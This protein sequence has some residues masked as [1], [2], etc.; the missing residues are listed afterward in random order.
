MSGKSKPAVK[1]VIDPIDQLQGLSNSVS[2]L[3]VAEVVGKGPHQPL[4]Y[5]WEVNKTQYVLTN[6]TLYWTNVSDIP[7]KIS[8]ATSNALEI[9]NIQLS[10]VGF[11]RVRLKS[12]TLTNTSD[13]GALQVWHHSIFTVTGTPTVASGNSGT[14]PGPYKGLLTYV[15]SGGG[16][17]PTSG[18]TNHSA[19]ASSPPT[20]AEAFLLGS[21]GD[22][23]CGTITTSVNGN[24]PPSVVYRVSVYFPST[25]PSGNYDTQLNG[26]NQ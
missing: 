1:V 20:D 12:G 10:D 6:K 25:V 22:Q 16:F 2:F 9:S 3:V 14:C 26:F 15:H 23:H 18:V 5:Q 8:G 13:P 24:P 17:T 4:E 21:S 7:G 11:Y 19:T